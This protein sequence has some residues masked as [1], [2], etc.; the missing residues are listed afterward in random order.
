MILVEGR[1]TKTQNKSPTLV[2][3]LHERVDAFGVSR[4]EKVYWVYIF[5]RVVAVLT[6]TFG[7]PKCPKIELWPLKN[8][9]RIRNLSKIQK[10]KLWKNKYLQNRSKLSKKGAL[11]GNIDKLFENLCKQK[12]TFLQ[13]IAQMTNHRKKGSGICPEMWS[14]KANLKDVLRTWF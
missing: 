1:L 4:V 8:F 7:G 2:I 11:F 12:L 10:K 14:Q 5:E 9:W 3:I 6:Q 13:K